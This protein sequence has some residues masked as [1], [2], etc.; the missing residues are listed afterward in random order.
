MHGAAVAAVVAPIVALYPHTYGK[1]LTYDP[2]VDFV[3]IAPLAA[4]T[5]SMTVGPMVPQ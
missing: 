5:M 1:K 4:Y 3:A 2:L